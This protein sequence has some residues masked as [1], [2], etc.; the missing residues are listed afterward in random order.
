VTV[1]RS[2]ASYR[3]NVPQR[4]VLFAG[5]G[6][7]SFKEWAACAKEALAHP[8]F[9]TGFRF[10]SDRRRIDAERSDREFGEVTAFIR[11]RAALLGPVRWGVLVASDPARELVRQTAHYAESSLVQFQSFVN[12][13]AALLWIMQ[14]VDDED[15]DELVA[16]VESP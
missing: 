5:E 2:A 15:L 11:A 10:L 14:V 6:A 7:I 13:R 4:L 1:T 16:W 9:R 3:I 8:G 12:P